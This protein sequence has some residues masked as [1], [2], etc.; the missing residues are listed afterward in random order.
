MTQL[1]IPLASPIAEEKINGL[2]VELEEFNG[3][4]AC[5]LAAANYIVSSKVKKIV[6][7]V[8]G[9]SA[10][11]NGLIR[12]LKSIFDERLIIK[13]VFDYTPGAICTSLMGLDELNP[14]K[15]LIVT[16]IDQVIDISI[17][18]VITFFRNK[19]CDGG[20]IT[21]KSRN[22][23]WSYALTEKN[24]VIQTA[25]KKPISN[26][27]IAG[28]YYFK[29]THEFKEASFELI[30]KRANQNKDGFYISSVFNELVIKHKK[31][32]SYEIPSNKYIK[33]LSKEVLVNYILNLS[34][35]DQ[36]T[37]NLENLSNNYA[38]IFNNKNLK[39]L[40][41]IFHKDAILC[42]VSKNIFEGKENIF[43][44]LKDF[45]D[46][47]KIRFEV[48]NIEV[49]QKTQTSII[50]FDLI[51]NDVA[52]TGVDIINWEMDKIKRITAYFFQK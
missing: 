1:L 32:V 10:E 37:Y 33:F 42:E 43:N 39:E 47:N 46:N 36:S 18:K 19:K 22:P 12:V 48:L 30:Y 17:D 52:F 20:L 11:K 24:H 34:S 3:K 49:A 16:S 7:V 14:S 29:S 4:M 8:H 21:F 40:D 15:E 6:I 44:M 35:Q 51:V 28:F 5:E 26:L 50:E 23:R 25:E 9:P 31:V 27:A 13:K 45:F 38:I 2:P 41:K